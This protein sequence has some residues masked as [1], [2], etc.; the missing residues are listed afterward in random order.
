MQKSYFTI[1]LLIILAFCS[2][3]K[4][5]EDYAVGQNEKENEQIAKQEQIKQAMTNANKVINAKEEE[6]I[7]AYIE[8]R[9]WQM[10]EDGGVFYEIISEGKGKKIVDINKVTIKYDCTL[11]SGEKYNQTK[12]NQISFLVKGDTGV[13]F[14][15]LSI[16]KKLKL[17]SKARVIVPSSLAFTLDED[18]GKISENN[19]LIYILEVVNIK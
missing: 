15:L 12:D 16:M 14:G 1:L 8:R 13:P 4:Y 9:H 19:T 18:G 7:R 10:R 6:N 3:K 17:T 2:C 5:N 11:L